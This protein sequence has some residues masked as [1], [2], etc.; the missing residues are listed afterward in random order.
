ME[1]AE[2]RMVSVLY[3]EEISSLSLETLNALFCASHQSIMGLY[4]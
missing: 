1:K 3:E 2:T 4:E